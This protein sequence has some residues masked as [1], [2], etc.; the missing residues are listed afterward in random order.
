[1][2]INRNVQ[3]AIP[4]IALAA[5]VSLIAG[6]GEDASE[7]EMASPAAAMTVTLNADRLEIYE[8]NCKICHGLADSGAPQTGVVADWQERS[9]M[10]MD[11]LLDNAMNGYQAMPPMGGCFHCTEDDFRQLISF[12]TSG[13]VN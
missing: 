11:V 4:L 6:C 13:L 10:G 3:K 12:M 5:L 9:A 1:M 8:T 2:M 7:A